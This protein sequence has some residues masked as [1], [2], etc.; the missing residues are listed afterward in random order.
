M[1]TG[2]PIVATNIGAFTERLKDYHSALLVP[3]DVDGEELA[4]QI[5]DY[6][7]SLRKHSAS[8]AQLATTLSV[9]PEK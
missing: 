8:E 6:L 4:R 3:W 2:R 7:R 9:R 5:V 1:R